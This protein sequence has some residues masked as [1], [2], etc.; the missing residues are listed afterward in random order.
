MKMDFCKL[1]INLLVFNYYQ[2][3]YD[4]YEGFLILD[5]IDKQNIYLNKTYLC[6]LHKLKEVSII[7]SHIDYETLH[8]KRK[9]K[10]IIKAIVN[11]LYNTLH[12]EKYIYYNKSILLNLIK[13]L[14]NIKLEYRMNLRSYKKLLKNLF[15]TIENIDI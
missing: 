8:I 13:Y 4:I 3:N 7:P 10:L 11:V 15:C 14:Y 2:N 9:Y 12:N 6:E 5:F 1:L